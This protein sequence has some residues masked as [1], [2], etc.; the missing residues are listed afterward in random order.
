VA[1]VRD[2][3]D[4][5]GRDALGRL[6]T[7]RSVRTAR[8]L[9]DRRKILAYSYRGDIE[10]LLRDLRRED[11]IGILADGIVIDD[12]EYTVP[13][14]ARLSVGEIRDLAIKV[15]VSGVMPGGLMP[16][17][18]DDEVDREEIPE[19]F[20]AARVLSTK[21]GDRSSTLSLEALQ[22]CVR[23]S[24]RVSLASAFFDEEFLEE[25]FRPLAQ[26]AHR[27]AVRLLFNGLAG[28]RLQQQLEELR[29]VEKALRRRCKKLHIRLK[30]EDGLFH[31]KLLICETGSTVAF[32]GSANATMAAL[33]RNEEILVRIQDATE[34]KAYF[35]R[36]WGKG[37]DVSEMTE[38]LPRSLVAFFRT[39][40]LFFKPATQLQTTFNPFTGILSLLTD[41]ERDR[42]ARRE[43]PIPNADAD[44][45]IGA[46][47]IKKALHFTPDSD[48]S[49][50][51]Q[52]ESR[53][54]RK[55][56]P[57][58]SYSVE[59]CLGYW[60]PS[61]LRAEFEAKLRKAGETKK[62]YY[63][64]LRTAV[65]NQPDN[66]FRKGYCDYR[67]AV[68]RLFHESNIDLDKH[69]ASLKASPFSE[70]MGFERFLNALRE[71]LDNESFIKRLCVPFIEGR[72]PEIWNDPDATVEFEN[73]F[74]DYLEYIADK[75]GNRPRVPAIIL[76]QCE[77]VH[78]FLA[79]DIRSALVARLRDDDWDSSTW[80]G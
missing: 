11:L 65:A 4:F 76:A 8:T 25:L 71:K 78:G 6:A 59:T 3:L 60:V 72:V 57:I 46:F 48:G 17:P 55:T 56:P 45:G 43:A 14:L 75:N 39:G 50:V 33:E 30:Y 32:V 2:C 42:L 7:I 41:D 38:P 67:M 63:D 77:L 13:G 36:V 70:P 28:A 40:V 53:S 18:E 54:T 20:P 19:E 37:K 24:H 61:A 12:R 31:S 79:E 26:A 69:F 16:R 34:L 58:R 35:E 44:A 27:P 49:G 64:N 22:T 52:D 1:T 62:L 5:L 29:R 47:S 15:Y 74:F 66:F 10:T 73:S 21:H 23:S 9:D 68:G 51:K 80:I